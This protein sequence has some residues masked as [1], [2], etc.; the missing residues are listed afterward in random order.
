MMARCQDIGNPLPVH[1]PVVLPQQVIHAGVALVLVHRHH[2]H[3]VHLLVRWRV[4]EVLI[5]VNLKLFM[6]VLDQPESHV[7]NVAHSQIDRT[8]TMC[9]A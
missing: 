4:A 1:C 3:V 8:S 9:R 5:V 6:A 2:H 7:L